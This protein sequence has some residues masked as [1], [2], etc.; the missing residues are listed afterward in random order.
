MST[1]RD[2]LINMAITH[3]DQLPIPL[4]LHGIIVRYSRRVWTEAL[5]EA[6]TKTHTCNAL[7]LSLVKN[8]A[9]HMSRSQNGI[10]ALYNDKNTAVDAA[11]AINMLSEQKNFPLS[12]VLYSAEGVLKDEIWLCNT[13]YD[14]ETLLAIGPSHR[15]LLHRSFIPSFNPVEDVGFFPAPHVE[16]QRHEQEF[17]YLKDYRSYDDQKS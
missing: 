9:I 6:H 10:Q 15:L 4:T 11:C 3:P 8:S 1:Q 16:Q 7:L 14:A 17:F 2:R 12:A 13:Q 5:W